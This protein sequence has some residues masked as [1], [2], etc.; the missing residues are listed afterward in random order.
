MCCNDCSPQ[1][2]MSAA[3]WANQFSALNALPVEIN[4]YALFLEA[5]VSGSK[6]QF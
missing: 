2:K 4:L 1:K 5:Y 6:A 3:L